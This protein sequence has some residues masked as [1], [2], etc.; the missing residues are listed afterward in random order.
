MKKIIHI[1]TSTP[2][3]DWQSEKAR[4]WAPYVAKTLKKYY[5]EYEIE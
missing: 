3:G 2:F 5:P 4:G 1:N